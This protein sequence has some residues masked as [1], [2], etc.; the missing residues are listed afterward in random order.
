MFIEYDKKPKESNEILLKKYPFLKC[1]GSPSITW[2]DDLESGWRESFGLLLCKELKDAI[3]EEGCQDTF[4]FDQIKEKYAELRLYAH[5]Y[6]YNG[7][8][9]NILSKYEELSK[10]ICG[11]C[12]KPATKITR[13]WIYPVCDDCIKDIRG[14]YSPIEEFYNFNSYGDVRA[15]IINIIQK[16]KKEN[17]W[18][19]FT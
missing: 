2:L 19:S 14:G 5:G 18:K 7:P 13:G 16:Y 8:V 11:H 1:E 15:E 10:Y 17:Y 9:D 12:G 3:E 6:S 4:G